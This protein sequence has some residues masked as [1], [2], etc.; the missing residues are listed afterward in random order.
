MSVGS[1][2]RTERHRREWGQAELA[3]LVG[4]TAG[5]VSHWESERSIPKDDMMATLAQVFEISVEYLS[6]GGSGKR[7]PE[8]RPHIDNLMSQLKELVAQNNSVS[9]GRVMIEIRIIS[10][11]R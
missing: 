4:C 8:E 9:I 11:E 5:A 1:I 2:I 6:S 7:Y 3:A 10:P